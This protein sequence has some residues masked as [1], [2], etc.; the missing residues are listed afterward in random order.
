MAVL[1]CNLRHSATLT[2]ALLGRA[3]QGQGCHY[4]AKSAERQSSLCRRKE[5]EWFVHIWS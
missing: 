2:E 5:R 1:Q 3:L 4:S